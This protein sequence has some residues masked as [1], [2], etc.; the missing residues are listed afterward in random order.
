MNLPIFDDE[1][2]FYACPDH[3]S[4][5]RRTGIC[6]ICLHLRLAA[7]CPECAETHHC[8]SCSSIENQPTTATTTNNQFR[9]SRSV[10]VT[11]ERKDEEGE[12]GR[13]KRRGGLGGFWKGLLWGSNWGKSGRVEAE[14]DGIVS[15]EM[16]RS[17]S[18]VAERTGEKAT[19]G[20][21]FPSPRKI[22]LQSRAMFVRSPSRLKR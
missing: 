14:K 4:P 11:V 5:H 2:D 18:T 20:W 12:E 22:L 16:R 17:R 21:S 15:K 6:P 9:R 8:C 3:P 7:L 19:G 13:G 1:A 10:A